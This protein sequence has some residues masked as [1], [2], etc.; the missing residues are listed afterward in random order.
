[1]IRKFVFKLK[2]DLACLQFMYTFSVI[3][4]YIYNYLLHIFRYKMSFDVGRYKE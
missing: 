1:M 4:S 3:F 2:I